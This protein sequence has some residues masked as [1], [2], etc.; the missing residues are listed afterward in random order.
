M[1]VHMIGAVLRVVF[2]HE[3]CGVLPD[4]A[5][6]DRFH[7]LA[8]CVVVVGYL[9]QRALYIGTVSLRVIV[10]ETYGHK[11]RD[12]IIGEHQIE[13]ALPLGV[14]AWF[15]V[16]SV[17]RGWIG[18]TISGG[19]VT[20]GIGCIVA[21]VVVVA[22]TSQANPGRQQAGSGWI[23]FGEDTRHAEAVEETVV[24]IRETR[25]S[26]GIPDV[27]A[28]SFSHIGNW[29][30]PVGE[31]WRERV[32]VGVLGGKSAGEVAVVLALEV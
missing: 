3:D 2:D 5:L 23:V 16:V 10:H 27:T 26:N 11:G 13:L 24:A 22:D 30:Q 8:Y 31:G 19:G 25:G 12:G 28:G 9:S 21:T 20:V 15:V 7:Q 29:R 18:A 4:G 32:A 14:A 1:R 17:D 6:A